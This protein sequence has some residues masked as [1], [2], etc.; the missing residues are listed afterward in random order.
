MLKRN[1]AKSVLGVS[2]RILSKT[3]AATVLQFINNKIDKPLTI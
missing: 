3:T 1:Y 2:V